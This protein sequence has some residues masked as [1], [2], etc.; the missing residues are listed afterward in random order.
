[1]G[2][3]VKTKTKIGKRT[4]LKKKTKKEV[5]HLYECSVTALHTIVPIVFENSV[6]VF[7]F[8]NI[9]SNQVEFLKIS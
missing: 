6:Y 4:N 5:S 2:I 7:A 1:M 3:N 8:N 9:I